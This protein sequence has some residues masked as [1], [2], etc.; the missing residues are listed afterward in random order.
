MFTKK[1]LVPPSE[2]QLSYIKSLE[3]KSKLKFYGT[4]T[5]EAMQFIERAKRVIV[6]NEIIKNKLKREEERLKNR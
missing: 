3:H 1:Q 6:E 5:R 4:T 2:K